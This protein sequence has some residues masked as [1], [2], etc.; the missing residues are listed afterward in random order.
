VAS[1]A[2]LSLYSNAVVIPRLAMSQQQQQ[3]IDEFSGQP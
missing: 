3:L 1:V 2:C